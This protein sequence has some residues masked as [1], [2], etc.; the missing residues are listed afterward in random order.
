MNSNKQITTSSFSLLYY[1]FRDSPIYSISIFLVVILTCIVLIWKIVIPLTQRWFSIQREVRET[2]AKIKIVKAN[3]GIMQDLDKTNLDDKIDTAI[4][5]VPADK[6]FF[7][8]F[9]AI[10]DS[11]VKSGVLLGKFSFSPGTLASDSASTS[12]SERPIDVSL[13]IEGDLEDIKS[14]MKE[15]NE[16]LPLSESET[17]VADVGSSTEAKLR[18]LFTYKTFPLITYTYTEPIKS[19][20]EEELSLINQLTSWKL[21]I[22]D[23]FGS[24]DASLP[25][26]F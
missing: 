8:I 18:L 3:I 20:T 10:V 24:A 1:R 5:A 9:T 2:E 26:P 7:G 15:I 12:K 22:V 16:K 19:F 21:S 17:L 6:D 23:K 11:A 13:P 14:F 25:P 4:A